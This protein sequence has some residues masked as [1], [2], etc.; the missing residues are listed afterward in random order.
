MKPSLNGKTSTTLRMIVHG[1]LALAAVS[2]IVGVL[3]SLYVLVR[4][5][6]SMTP[7]IDAGLASSHEHLLIRVCQIV[8]VLTILVAFFVNILRS[9][10]SKD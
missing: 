2:A 3:S 1:S 10:A 6:L 4:A 8:F 5:R 9:K 7:P